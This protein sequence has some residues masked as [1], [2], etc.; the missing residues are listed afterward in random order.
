[1]IDL[2][3]PHGAVCVSFQLGRR[4]LGDF[5]G[6][7]SRGN[8]AA[9]GPDVDGAI[10]I[11]HV[12]E[13]GEQEA[14]QVR[15]HD[16]RLSEMRPHFTIVLVDFRHFGHWHVRDDGIIVPVPDGDLEEGLQRRLVPAWEGLSRVD[17]YEIGCG[18]PSEIANRSLRYYRISYCC[19]SIRRARTISGNKDNR[20]WILCS[21]HVTAFSL[22]VISRDI[23]I[24]F[25]SSYQYCGE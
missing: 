9:S 22:V 5:V 20:H 19:A 18:E 7:T 3:H 4:F 17:R 6:K 1:V 23:S 25:Y 11:A 8:C 2:W 12:T 16:G 14:D 21:S 13:I 15:R 24:L 10:G